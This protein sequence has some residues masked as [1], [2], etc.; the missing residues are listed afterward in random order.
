MKM[1]ATI[2]ALLL[3]TAVGG[4]AAGYAALGGSTGVRIPYNGY[5]ERNGVPVSGDVEIIVGLFSVESGGSA[6]TSQ[7]FP[8]VTASAGRFALT[9]GPVP[10]ACVRGEDV[11]I[12]V[13]IDD[14]SGPVTLPQRTRI[15][16]ALSAHTSGAGGDF[17]VDSNLTVVGDASVGGRVAATAVSAGDAEIGTL[18]GVATLAASSRFDANAFALQQTPAGRTTLN[19]ATGQDVSLG[20][21]GTSRV[22][23]RDDGVTFHGVG[24]APDFDSGWVNVS[25][26]D[27]QVFN[28]NLGTLPTRFTFYVASK[29]DGTG[30]VTLGGNTWFHATQSDARGTI[31]TDI[32]ESSVRAR[33]GQRFLFD[34]FGTGQAAGRVNPSS[35]SIRILA[36]R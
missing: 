27:E 1:R 6:C 22:E 7:T 36:W 8:S 17:D 31:L 34:T 11:F 20:I 30:V 24:L 25:T 33:V 10:E 29:V 26:G 12:E 16:P 13:G 2:Q 9:I 5:L 21:N 3:L 14:G 23:V 4:A 28:H 32:T 15:T 35:G 19:A 18:G